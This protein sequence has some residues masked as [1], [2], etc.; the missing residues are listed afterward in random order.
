MQLGGKYTHLSLSPLSVCPQTRK[1]IATQIHGAYEFGAQLLEVLGRPVLERG[2]FSGDGLEGQQDRRLVQRHV[3]KVEHQMAPP[4]ARLL[5]LAVEYLRE[6]S[7]H[8]QSASISSTPDGGDDGYGG[9]TLMSMGSVS[10]C[11]SEAGPEVVEAMG[12]AVEGVEGGVKAKSPDCRSLSSGMR[13]FS[14]TGSPASVRES[15]LA[16]R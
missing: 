13:I 14:D 3:R 1:Q 6:S 5:D 8:L 16:N 4:G 2:V 15:H 12:G 9:R 7:Q 11:W 10:G